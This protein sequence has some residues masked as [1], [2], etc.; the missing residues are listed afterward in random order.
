MKCFRDVVIML[1]K[2]RATVVINM[3]IVKKIAY[4]VVFVKKDL[5]ETNMEI[6]YHTVNAV[7]HYY[8]QIYRLSS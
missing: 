3:M 1:A 4:P 2:K 6:V 8:K 7:C 5:L